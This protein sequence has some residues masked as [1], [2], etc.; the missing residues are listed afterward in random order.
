MS[1]TAERTGL[2]LDTLKEDPISG[3]TKIVNLAM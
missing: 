1:F 2:D 3:E